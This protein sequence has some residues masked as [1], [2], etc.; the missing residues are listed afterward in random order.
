M[1]QPYIKCPNHTSNVPNIALTAHG[2]SLTNLKKNIFFLPLIATTRALTSMVAAV[3]GVALFSAGQSRCAADGS[4]KAS[5]L[6][7]TFQ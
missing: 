3:A 6:Y 5:F 4:L 1:S 7:L 2:V